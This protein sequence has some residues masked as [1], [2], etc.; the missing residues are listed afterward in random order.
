MAKSVPK[1]SRG[2]SPVDQRV[3]ASKTPA[4]VWVIVGLAVFFVMGGLG[5][6][7]FVVW[8][9]IDVR[10]AAPPAGEAV[11]GMSKPVLKA[12]IESNGEVGVEQPSPKETVL[13][14][15]LAPSVIKDRSEEGQMRQEVLNRIDLMRALSDTDKD[16]LYAQVERAR[17]F[18]KIATIPFAQNRALAGPAQMDGLIK[19]LKGPALQKLLSD[20]TVALIIVGYA[21]RK[22]EETK[23][24]DISRNRAESVVEALKAKMDL[25]NVLHAVAMGGQDLFDHSDAEKNRVVE[26][27]AVQP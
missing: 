12:P 25:V 13:D 18:T 24:L 9:A 7:A 4:G 5:I 26:V 8:K 10:K 23:N 21:D 19:S 22:G 1:I 16:K 2:T 17:G 11:T 15:G 3:G 27:W 14:A 20:P 6:S